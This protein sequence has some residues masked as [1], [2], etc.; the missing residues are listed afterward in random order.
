MTSQEALEHFSKKR[1]K[2][3]WLT[4]AMFVV[5]FTL[6]IAIGLLVGHFKLS[7]FWLLAMISVNGFVNISGLNFITRRRKHYWNQ[8]VLV[9]RCQIENVFSL[10]QE[11]TGQIESCKQP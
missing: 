11:A 3:N 6:S 7:T 8:I 9:H 1:K 4:M 2:L 10:Q 5:Y